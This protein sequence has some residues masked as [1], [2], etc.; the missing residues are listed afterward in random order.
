MGITWVNYR[1][2][3]DSP[4]GS[5]FLPKWVATR[6]FLMKGQ[7]PY[8]EATTSEIQQQFYGRPA[9]A[10]EDQA[11]FIY[12]FYSI[13]VYGPFA[14]ISDYN[15][16]RAIWM[17]VLEVS[18]ILIVLAGIS[19][20]RWKPTP[21][22]LGALLIFALL[23][24]YGIRALINANTSVLIGLFVVIAFLAIRSGNDGW[25]GL[26]LALAT[27]KPHVV[28]LLILFILIWSISQ[29]RYVIF[30]SFLGNLALLIATTSLLIPDWTWQ[31]LRQI[32]AY[33]GYTLPSTPGEIFYSWMPGV[34]NQLGWAVTI[35][36]VATLIWEW[37]NA[38]GKDFRWFL[39]TAY[40]T[41]TATT[42]VGIRTAT[43]NYIILL[44]A[45]IL[46]FAAWDQ[47]WGWFGRLTIAISYIVLLV[48]VWW[49]FLATL[50]RGEQP[51]QS[52]LMFF[53]LPLFLFIGLYWVRWWVLRPERP[54]LDQLR[55]PRRLIN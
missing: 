19:L 14:I 42:M 39:W 43:E 50:E 6:A 5:D 29:R 54:F 11:L 31:N 53:P 2:S 47:E 17:T 40:L 1:Y 45:V 26:L 23:S 55:N 49:L 35:V 12:P 27:I 3:Q 24:Y 4:G 41:L 46:V 13:F 30:W 37:R 38:L 7:S 22:Q 33:P 18:I 20:S 52:S 32:V 51:I 34:G 21:F 36:V 16:A 28:V 15:L 9:R 8:S 10:D 48:G 25:A 44:P